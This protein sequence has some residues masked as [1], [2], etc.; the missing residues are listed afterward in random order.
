MRIRVLATALGSLLLAGPAA[1]DTPDPATAPPAAAP[2]GDP[3]KL[4][5]SIPVGAMADAF[6]T[7]VSGLAASAAASAG[8]VAPS[9]A[10]PAGGVAPGVAAPG[11]AAAPSAGAPTQ[12]QAGAAAPQ[13]AAGPTLPERM[14]VLQA[15]PC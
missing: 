3:G 13:P 12:G 7:V 10:A 1:A 8:G 6:S 14:L 11:G 5:F 9:A 2:G 15:A 4:C